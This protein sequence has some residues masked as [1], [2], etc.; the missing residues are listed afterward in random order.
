MSRARTGGAATQSREGAP[1]RNEACPCG[2]GRRY[3]DCH[4]A[5][6]VHPAA[7]SSAPLSLRDAVSKQR[8]GDFA[9][10]FAIARTILENDPTNVD[11]H[12]VAA[13]C[14]HECGRND[15]ALS[16]LL[17]GAR[18]AALT[19]KPRRRL[20]HDI[21]T[22]FGRALSGIDSAFGAE[23]RAQYAEWLARPRERGRSD[24]PSV[25]VVI[26][27]TDDASRINRALASVQDQTLP[28]SEMIVADGRTDAVARERLARE[29][30][31]WAKPPRTLSLPGA[32]EAALIDA[33]VRAAASESVN[34]LPANDE[35]SPRRLERL[36]REVA[37]PGRAWGFGGVQF[38]DGHDVMLAIDKPPGD[39]RTIAELVTESDTVGWSFIHRQFVAVAV[40]N[41]FFR[42]DFFASV[43]GMRKLRHAH[44]WDFALRALAHEEPVY[45]PEP[46]YRR[47]VKAGNDATKSEAEYAE[48]HA[49]FRDFYAEACKADKRPAN[50]F[51]PCA[52]NWARHFYKAPLFAGHAALLGLDRLEW[53]AVALRGDAKSRAARSLDRGLDLVG[54]AFGEFGLAE[55]LRALA[56]ACLEGGIPFSVRDVDMRIR[57]RQV[58]RTLLPY[59]VSELSRRCTVFCLNPDMMQPVLPIVAAASAAGRRAVGYWYWELGVLPREWDY[60]LNRMDE[61]WAGSGFVA[62]SMRRSTT[63]PVVKIPPPIELTLSRAWRRADFGLPEDRFLFLFT[64]DFN[65]Y[66]KRKNPEGTIEAFKRAFAGRRDVGLVIKSMNGALQPERLRALR[67]RIDG[68]ERIL[69]RDEAMSRDE[70]LGLENA[71]D[72]FVSLHRAEGFGLGLA[73]AMYLGKPAI[74]TAYSGNLE[75]M[76]ESNSC[77]VNFELVPL[78]EGDYLY[79]D[80]RFHWAE[81]D[82]EHAAHHMRR[83]VDDAAFRN[84]IAA[85]GRH[86]VRTRFT[87]AATAALIKRRLLEVEAID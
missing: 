48:E 38:I 41:L 11:A 71:V 45:V 55:S 47:R 5:P 73:E 44:A 85:T 57:T 67:S 12:H 19:E 7:A 43:G 70:M 8:A 82:V 13:L 10:A 64:F 65:S 77:L 59:V 51:A 30:E 46:L 14:A 76:N 24:P 54:F 16:I 83:L 37:M 4:G 58:D 84:R 87:R 3:K 18:V 15:E 56:S 52:A 63:K 9:A 62:E 86:D 23:R 60:A 28:A 21:N 39:E 66:V 81:P 25:S 78:A 1:G 26:V 27:V 36:V 29:L 34:V 68:D 20:W 6:D 31:S 35:L 32:D 42:R 33:G 72:A 40:G 22:V 75:F 2:S 53:L 80:P 61:L 69:L 74:G 50:P 49:I 79:A 17:A